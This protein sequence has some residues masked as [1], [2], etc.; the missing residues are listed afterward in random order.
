M[1]TYIQRCLPANSTRSTPNG[2][3]SET[4]R[5]STYEIALDTLHVKHMQSPM[6]CT[7]AR[8]LSNPPIFAARRTGSFWSGICHRIRADGRAGRRKRFSSQLNK[9]RIVRYIP[10]CQ[11]GANRNPWVG[12]WMDPFPTS[13]A[14]I[15]P[16]NW[17]AEK[18]PFE[19]AAKWL[20]IPY[21]AIGG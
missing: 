3:Y 21:M 1:L 16:L 11:W 20:D 12:Y 17:R 13:T 18:S 8:D 4:W 19:V 14:P 5:C 7:D 10:L 2:M 15:P 6:H 9:S